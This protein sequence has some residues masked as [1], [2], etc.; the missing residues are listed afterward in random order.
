[1]DLMYQSSA[2]VTKQLVVYLFSGVMPPMYSTTQ[3]SVVRMLYV[4]T[5][6]NIPFWSQNFNT[7]R[8]GWECSQTIFSDILVAKAAHCKCVSYAMYEYGN[9]W[10][11]NNVACHDVYFQ[12]KPK[13]N[14][15]HL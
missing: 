10:K 14:N 4:V 6:K 11:S 7:K 9:G 2:N 13:R 15:L 12:L 3:Q 8:N 1:M 5:S